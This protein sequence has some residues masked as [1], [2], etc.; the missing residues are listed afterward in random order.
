MLKIF[1][2]KLNIL[3]GGKS[4]IGIESTIDLRKQPQILRLGGLDTTESSEH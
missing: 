1:G 2:K 3:D 4:S